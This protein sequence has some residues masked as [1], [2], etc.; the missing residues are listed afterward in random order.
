MHVDAAVHPLHESLHDG[1]AEAGADDFAL[2]FSKSH[3][4]FYCFYQFSSR[5][6]PINLLIFPVFFSHCA[7]LCLFSY[8]QVQIY[9]FLF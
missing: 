7:Q 4:I 9:D 2:E 3:F 8:I 5:L 6:S 1:Q